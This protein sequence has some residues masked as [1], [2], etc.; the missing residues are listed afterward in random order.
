M[1]TGNVT[2]IACPVCRHDKTKVIETTP[3]YREL[4]S[5]EGRITR[6]KFA[7][8]FTR[9]CLSVRCGREFRQQVAE[10]ISGS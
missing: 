9:R 6:E 1:I 8:V 10:P 7:T 3:L 5:V 4:P 2:T